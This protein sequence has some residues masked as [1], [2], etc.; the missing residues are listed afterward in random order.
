MSGESRQVTAIVKEAIRSGPEAA[1]QED[2]N[3]VKGLSSRS[4]LALGCVLT[5]I[6]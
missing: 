5:C 1:V 3:W 6:V 4:F 2:P